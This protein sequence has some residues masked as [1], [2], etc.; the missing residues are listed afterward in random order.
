MRRIVTAS[1]LFAL[2]AGI[3]QSHAATSSAA[4]ASVPEPAAAAVP[5]GAYTLDKAHAS[6]IFRLDHLGFSNFTARFT[7]FDAQLQFDPANLAASRVTVTIDPRSID[8]DNAPAGFMDQLRGTHWLEAAQFPEMTFRSTRIEVI[9]P[10]TMRIHGDLNLHGMTRPVVLNATFNGGY[11]GHPM[12]PHA[13]I[14][15]SAQGS[16]ERSEYGIAYGVPAPGSHMGVGDKVN[17]V[18]EAEFSGPPLAAA[19]GNASGAQK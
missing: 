12:D 18:I 10:N 16:L 9:A 8:S 6:L 14:G 2:A 5:A 1:A 3:S 13:R 17:V 19:A 11:A 15:F 7:R 4:R